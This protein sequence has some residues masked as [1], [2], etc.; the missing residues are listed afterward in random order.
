MRMILMKSFITSRSQ[1]MKYIRRGTFETNSSSCHSITFNNDGNNVQGDTKLLYAEARNIYCGSSNYQYD[2]DSGYEYDAGEDLG[3]PQEKFEYALICYLE[4]LETMANDEKEK[5]YDEHPDE[6]E[7][8]NLPE[9]FSIRWN[10]PLPEEIYNKLVDDYKATKSL[11][12]DIFANEYDIEVEWDIPDPRTLD[13]INSSKSSYTK[14]LFDVD[15]CIDHDSSCIQ[16]V[17]DAWTL[18]DMVRDPYQL[19]N[20]TFIDTN[21]VTLMYNG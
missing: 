4:Q 5:W 18:A 7:K 2:R 8:L 3:N 16:H 11:I 15:G 13:E 21:D 10:A 19:Y 1:N 12:I 17:E 9:G 14:N 20:W 6:K